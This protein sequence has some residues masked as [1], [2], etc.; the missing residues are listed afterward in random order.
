[1]PVR[2]RVQAL[3]R[4]LQRAAAAQQPSA[5]RC[6]TNSRRANFQ[7]LRLPLQAV[8]AV[9]A[10]PAVTAKTSI[11]R[12]QTVPQAVAEAAVLETPTIA[13]RLEL[14]TRA[15]I[16]I[17]EIRATAEIIVTHATAGTAETA[18][19]ARAVAAAAAREP[20]ATK[21]KKCCRDASLRAA[22][23][24]PA[25]PRAR[26]RMTS[27]RTLATRR[28]DRTRLRHPLQARLLALA[29]VANLRVLVL[30]RALALLRARQS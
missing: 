13:A 2:A 24:A 29:L 4:R 9:E 22:A 12:A 28:S 5:G 6:A 3:V 26:K 30:E 8:Q 23:V 18:E 16:A 17:P 21:A 20:R 15:T 7:Q 10:A 25:R 11:A 1:M 27:V 19:I 14:A